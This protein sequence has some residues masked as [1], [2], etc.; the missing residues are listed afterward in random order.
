MNHARS[1]W[2]LSGPSSGG[3]ISR[4]STSFLHSTQQQNTPLKPYYDPRV[5]DPLRTPSRSIQQQQQRS[6]AEILRSVSRRFSSLSVQELQYQ[7]PAM[8][9]GSLRSH[10]LF[11]GGEGPSEF[12][13]QH[14]QQHRSSLH[15][16]KRVA[17]EQQHGSAAYLSPAAAN[18]AGLT[19]QHRRSSAK[20]LVGYKS[21]PARR[22]SS[23][24]ALVQLDAIRRIS[25]P[26]LFDRSSNTNS[27][28]K[29]TP[30]SVVSA[31]PKPCDKLKF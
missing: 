10:T 7:H 23:S 9:Q 18:A 31:R 13:P 14:V 24:T 16:R 20:D 4:R 3:N 15:S 17:P 12:Y 30:Q 25:P 1:E 28:N 21:T 26:T 27:L 8:A 5:S 19:K 6:E 29:L 11:H 2:N 22:Y